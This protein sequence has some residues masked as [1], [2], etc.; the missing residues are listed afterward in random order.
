MDS[1]Q[2]AVTILSQL[3]GNKFIAMTGAK[4]FASMKNG[5]L[6]FKLPSNFAKNGINTVKIELM[7]SDTYDVTF[8]N[9]RGVNVKK[10]SFFTD[11]YCDQLQ[12]IFTEAT[13]LNT[14]L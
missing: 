2:I 4:Q 6:I 11:V 5:G 13:G 8:F 7:P 14:Y 9:I 3:G 10:V 12:D 1:K